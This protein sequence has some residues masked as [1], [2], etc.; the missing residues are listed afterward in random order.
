MRFG[1]GSQ[2]INFGQMGDIEG[3]FEGAR[4]NTRNGY[5]DVLGD[6]QG[7]YRRSQE[8]ARQEFSGMRE[9]VQGRGEDLIGGIN[10]AYTDAQNY[11]PHMVQNRLQPE[12]Q[13]GMAQLAD[14]GMID[15]SIAGDTLSQLSRGVSQD[16]LAQQ[17][18]LEGERA[19]ALSE[20]DSQIY[21]TLANMDTQQAQTL[22]Q[23]LSQG[24]ESQSQLGQQ[25]Q[26]LLGQLSS[27]EAQTASQLQ[28]S[29]YEMLANM[30][31]TLLESSVP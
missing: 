11:L 12:L 1:Q 10:T 18:Q 14:R 26:N 23:I 13:R 8:E 17:A 20:A 31:P 30:L 24:A 16:I 15:S 5:Q 3:F 19:G 21:N 6:I 9:N 27:Q 28:A 2:G 29:E 22:S 25:Y 7:A 4:D